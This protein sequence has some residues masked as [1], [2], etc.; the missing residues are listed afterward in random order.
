MPMNL[1]QKQKGAILV[2]TAVMLPLLLAFMGLAVDLSNVFAAHAK[3]QSA[4]DAAALA[5]ASVC[6]KTNNTTQ[7]RKKAAQIFRKN[8][9]MSENSNDPDENQYA[10]TFYRTPGDELSPGNYEYFYVANTSEDVPFYFLQ[11]LRVFDKDA[12]AS[13]SISAKAIAKFTITDEASRE[14][15]SNAYKLLINVLLKAVKNQQLYEAGNE[16]YRTQPRV[17]L[18]NAN[19]S[20]DLIVTKETRGGR[21][22]RDGG[23]YGT[24]RINGGNYTSGSA[25]WNQI[26]Y[27]LDASLNGLEVKQQNGIT[28]YGVRLYGDGTALY[29]QGDNDSRALKADPNGTF[30]TEVTSANSKDYPGVRTGTRL[31]KTARG[32]IYYRSN[33]NTYYQDPHT[34]LFNSNYMNAGD[35]STFNPDS[36]SEPPTETEKPVLVSNDTKLA[37]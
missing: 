34:G 13:T 22:G 20:V 10:D 32:K 11:L 29:F 14:D 6:Q 12:P 28:W 3:L 25:L 31:Y 17:L 35:Q 7:A 37:H 2:L 18:P 36:P 21:N 33:G 23:Q 8:M 1:L 5:G 24:I 30:F 26:V 27:P 19:S 15:R 16:F 4:A 9:N